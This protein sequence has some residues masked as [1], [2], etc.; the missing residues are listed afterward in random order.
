[1]FA[2]VT[3]LVAVAATL[4]LVGA[5]T[6]SPINC[7]HHELVSLSY[8]TISLCISN[9]D[10]PKCNKC[11]CMSMYLLDRQRENTHVRCTRQSPR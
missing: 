4:A 1:M 3:Q 10:I 7:S 5:A 9:P 11:L 2:R 6:A 8:I